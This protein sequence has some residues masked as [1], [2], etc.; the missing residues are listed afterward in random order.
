MAL[1]SG[2]SGGGDGGAA[3]HFRFLRALDRSLESL[4]IECGKLLEQFNSI[5][6]RA[7]LYGERDDK[8]YLL[9]RIEDAAI[10]TV[11]DAAHFMMVDKPA[12]FYGILAAKFFRCDFL[13]QAYALP[14][15]SSAAT[16]RQS[17]PSS[18]R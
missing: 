13:S 2:S 6:K 12:G 16:G 14:R 1:A 4:S 7:F 5:K 9:P 17:R 11:P 8:G 15:A 3:C 18:P 10:S